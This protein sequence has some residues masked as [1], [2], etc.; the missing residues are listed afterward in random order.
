MNTT[1]TSRM[2]GLFGGAVHV[3]KGQRDPKRACELD[4]PGRHIRRHR[5]PLFVM[6]HVSLSDADTARQRGLAES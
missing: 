6:G 1:H 5:L 4:Q 2:A 3:I